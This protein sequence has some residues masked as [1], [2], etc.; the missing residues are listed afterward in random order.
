M[1]EETKGGPIHVIVATALIPPP[2]VER[3]RGVMPDGVTVSHAPV[4]WNDTFAPA[5]IAAEWVEPLSVA[6]VLV[7]FPQQ[8]LGLVESAPALRWVQY[9]GAGYE[10][11]PLA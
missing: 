8:V 6:H 11:A 9:Y 2:V 5:E 3:M 4:P 1:D 10:G 7:G